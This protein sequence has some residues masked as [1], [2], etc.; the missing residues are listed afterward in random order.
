MP[1]SSGTP[2]PAAFDR[3]S[4]LLGAVIVIYRTLPP[5]LRQKFRNRVL[6][7]FADTVDTGDDC[8][9]LARAPALKA[10]SIEAAL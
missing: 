1:A 7:A 2:C 3:A 9:S 6:R 8:L 4:G 5:L 10:V